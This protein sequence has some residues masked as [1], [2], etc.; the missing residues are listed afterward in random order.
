M[1]S[2]KILIYYKRKRKALS[3]MEEKQMNTDMTPRKRFFEVVTHG[4]PDRAVYDLSGSPQT[5]VDYEVTRRDLMRLLGITGEKQGPFNVDERVLEALHIDTRR[6][7]G[8]PIR[9]I[10]SKILRGSFSRDF[11]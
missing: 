1:G 6:V 9:R 3:R 7:G 8:M 2:R 10:F 5:N 11:I 4:N